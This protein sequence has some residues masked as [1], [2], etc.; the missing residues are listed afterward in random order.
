MTARALYL[1]LRLRR[2]H[3]KVNVTKATFSAIHNK[4]SGESYKGKDL[5]QGKEERKS[6]SS[7]ISRAE[8]A[9]TDQD[10]DGGEAFSIVE[11]SD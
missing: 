11:V 3:K 2:Q 6:S 5:A 1:S 10:D 9:S 7:A 8:G 4:K